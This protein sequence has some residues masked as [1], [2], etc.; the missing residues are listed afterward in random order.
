MGL[1]G[2]GELVKTKEGGEGPGLVVGREASPSFLG[3]WLSTAGGPGPVTSPLWASE[4][5]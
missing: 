3:R 1:E 5:S 2:Q 4:A